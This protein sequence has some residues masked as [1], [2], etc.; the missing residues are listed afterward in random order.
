MNSKTQGEKKGLI[1]LG[2][3]A[4]AG[5]VYLLTRKSANPPPAGQEEE[6]ASASVSVGIVDSSGNPVPH[7]SPF[8]L[9]EGESYSIE[10][11]VANRSYKL[12][13]DGITKIPVPLNLAVST[14]AYIHHPGST[15]VRVDFYNGVSGEGYK[16]VSM[17]ENG[18]QAFS[19]PFSVPMNTG[20]YIG[21]ISVRVIFPDGSHKDISNEMQVT[22]AQ[23]V[24][25]VDLS[26]S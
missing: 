8:P 10:L 23:I 21:L 20:G 15:E 3:A 18:S 22:A 1:A 25:D 16:Q 4:V 13:S 19:L 9:A 12:L 11:N 14:I 7:N 6:T 24:Y 17:A 26:F 2:L 5:G